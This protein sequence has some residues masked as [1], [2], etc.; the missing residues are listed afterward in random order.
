MKRGLTSPIVSGKR[1]SEPHGD[2]ASLPSEW[3][4]SKTQE[5]AGVGEGVPNGDPS[6]TAGGR[7]TWSRHSGEPCGDPSEHPR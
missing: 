6:G 5:T 3:L 7:A 1:Q 2:A 4:S